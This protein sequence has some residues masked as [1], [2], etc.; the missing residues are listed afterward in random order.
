MKREITQSKERK[1]LMMVKIVVT[2]STEI[3]Y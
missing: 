3:I 2:Q 1:R